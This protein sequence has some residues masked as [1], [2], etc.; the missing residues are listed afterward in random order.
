MM[1]SFLISKI[2]HCITKGVKKYLE[3]KRPSARIA[4]QGF[5]NLPI[6]SNHYFELAISWLSNNLFSANAKNVF[7]SNILLM[8]NWLYQVATTGKGEETGCMKITTSTQK[9]II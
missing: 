9:A 4:C 1:N 2:S 6:C 7:I 3:T 5:C 8:G